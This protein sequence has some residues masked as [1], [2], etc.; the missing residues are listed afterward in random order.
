MI[1][2]NS[3]VQLHE[4]RK[5]MIRITRSIPSMISVASVYIDTLSNTY[6]KKIHKYETTNCYDKCNN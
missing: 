1:L 6:P 5:I 4:G 3:I 2:N